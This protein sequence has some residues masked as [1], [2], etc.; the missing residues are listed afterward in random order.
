MK[1]ESRFTPS[2]VRAARAMEA[3][4]AF[5]NVP[6]DNKHARR[7]LKLAA[8]MLDNYDRAV[9]SVHLVTGISVHEQVKACMREL[10]A[11]RVNL[12]QQRKQRQLAL[13]AE[14]A[15]A[16]ELIAA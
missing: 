12:A 2:I 3:I 5:I 10:K 15:M 11:H 6:A 16:L 1:I 9:R 4:T 14:R 7:G 13:E 8:D